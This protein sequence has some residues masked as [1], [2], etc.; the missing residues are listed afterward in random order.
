MRLPPGVVWLASYPKSGNTWL[1]VLLSNMLSGMPTPSDIND[2]SVRSWAAACSRLEF[3][4]LVEPQL[5]RLPEMEVL[6]AQ[7]LD[8]EA[9]AVESA[10]LSKVHDAWGYLADGTPRLGRS[11][12]RALYVLRDPRD[13]AVSYAFYSGS[14]TTAAIGWMNDAE[15]RIHSPGRTIPQHLSDWSGH[16]RSWTQQRDV[17][18][19]VIRYEDLHANTAAVL[20]DALDFLGAVFDHDEDAQEAIAR[21]VR[22]S[23]FG[24]LQQQEGEKGFQERLV[25]AAHTEKFFRRGQVG[26]WRNHLSPPQVQRLE[27]A[28]GETMRRFGY[29]PE[30]RSVDRC[31]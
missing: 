10:H 14:N 26:D 1:R 2:L 24:R 11:A 18:V 31:D 19:H 30:R 25:G 5:L 22:H 12:R 29:L 20:R 16:V 28:H 23:D 17:P 13:V 6:R 9:Q 7:A 15:F 4:M 27:D 8:A 3:H 21:A